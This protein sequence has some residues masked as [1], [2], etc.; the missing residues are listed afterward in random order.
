[1]GPTVGIMC[2]FTVTYRLK[3]KFLQKKLS[4]CPAHGGDGGMVFCLIPGAPRNPVKR[5]G[6]GMD[7]PSVGVV[8]GGV[9]DVGAP[10]DG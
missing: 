9:D 7:D 3:N 10:L 5:E 8:E 1:M 2:C 4:M 6:E